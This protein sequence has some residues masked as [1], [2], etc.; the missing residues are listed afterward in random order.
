[1]EIRLF[2]VGGVGHVDRARVTIAQLAV[3]CHGRGVTGANRGEINLCSVQFSN[4]YIAIRALRDP[5]PAGFKNPESVRN[6]L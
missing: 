5:D 2:K 6:Y 4:T 3:L 1:V